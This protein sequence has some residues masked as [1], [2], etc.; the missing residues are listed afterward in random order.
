[1]ADRSLRSDHRQSETGAESIA[2]V[3]F[4]RL[5]Q[6]Q[7]QVTIVTADGSILT[8]NETEN[9]D[10]FWAI[11]GGGSNFGVVTEFVY[12]LHPQRRTIFAGTVIFTPAQAEKVVEVTKGWWE[13]VGEDEG[14]IQAVT[15]GPDGTGFA[16]CNRMI[17]RSLDEHRATLSC[18]CPFL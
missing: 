7:Q 15:C 4:I 6:P 9:P 18:C 5:Y 1:M 14:L 3:T 17:Y 11:R 13:N 8:A 2:L 16:A 10:L 12:Q